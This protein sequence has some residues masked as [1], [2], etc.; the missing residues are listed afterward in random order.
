VVIRL[1]AELRCSWANTC[2]SALLKV[3]GSGSNAHQV[4]HHS[5]QRPTRSA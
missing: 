4:L 5:R 3:V 1:W 2:S